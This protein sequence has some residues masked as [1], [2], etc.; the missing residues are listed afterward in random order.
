MTAFWALDFPGRGAGL[1]RDPAGLRRAHAGRR[2]ERRRAAEL[3]AGDFS[4][5]GRP[6]ARRAAGD[7]DRR[8]PGGARLRGGPRRPSHAAGGPGRPRAVGYGA[9]VERRDRCGSASRPRSRATS[10]GWRS[11]PAGA[12]ELT[13]RGHEVWVQAG[14]GAGVGPPRRGVRARRRAR[15]ATRRGRLGRRAGAEGEGAPAVRVRLPPR[16][17]GPLHLPAP[18]RQPGR[19]RRAAAGGHDGHRLR[20]RRGPRGAP[21]PARAR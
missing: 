18:R 16:R 14:A 9:S 21:A 5:S 1:R 11:T 15:S 3:A 12:L 17:P 13:R 7:R 8:G 6:A 10:T 19:R 20:D 4:L 2:P